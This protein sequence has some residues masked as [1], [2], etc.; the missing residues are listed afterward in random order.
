MDQSLSE[1]TWMDD[2][3]IAAPMHSTTIQPWVTAQTGELS[4]FEADSDMEYHAYRQ[5][6]LA[7]VTI[8]CHDW[9]FNMTGITIL[10]RLRLPGDS[11]WQLK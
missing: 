2:T 3:H 11:N 4:V 5:Y 6:V 7:N 8:P 9:S 1:S 10:H